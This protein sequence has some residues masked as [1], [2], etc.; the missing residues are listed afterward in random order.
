MSFSSIQDDNEIINNYSSKNKISFGVEL[1]QGK[2]YLITKNKMIKSIR[3]RNNKVEGFDNMGLDESLQLPVKEKNNDEIKQLVSLQNSFEKTLQQW[4]GKYSD[5]LSQIDNNKGL[6]QQCLDTCNKH[7]DRDLLTACIYGCTSGKYIS[8]GASYRGPAPP[9]AGFLSVLEVLGSVVAVAGILAAVALLGPEIAGIALLSE[10]AFDFATIA[11]SAAEDLSA[12]L[13]AADSVLV[14]GAVAASEAMSA[15]SLASSSMFGTIFDAEAFAE[16][17]TWAITLGE[18][19][20]ESLMAMSFIVGNETITGLALYEM[21]KKTCKLKENF[22]DLSLKDKQKMAVFLKTLPGA[23]KFEEI[24]TPTKKIKSKHVNKNLIYYHSKEGF[25]GSPEAHAISSVSGRSQ[26]IYKDKGFFD[27]A[28]MGDYGPAGYKFK[29]GNKINDFKKMVNKKLSS[30]PQLPGDSWFTGKGAQEDAKS[31]SQINNVNPNGVRAEM[32]KATDAFSKILKTMP[33]DPLILQMQKADLGPDNLTETMEKL[34]SQWRDIFTSV[35]E[36]GINKDNQGSFA[37]HQQ[38][39]KSWTNT[40]EGRSGYFGDKWIVDKNGNRQDNK[41]IGKTFNLNN[42][43]DVGTGDDKNNSRMG[44]DIMIPGKRSSDSNIGGAGYCECTDGSK[45]YMDEGHPNITCNDMCY[46]ENIK[47]KGKDNLFYHDSSVWKP[48]M[49]AIPG[50]VG[51]GAFNLSP[52]MNSQTPQPWLNCGVEGS[53]PKDCP[54]GMKQVGDV[55]E[56][57]ECGAYKDRSRLPFWEQVADDVDI[58][59]TPYPAPSVANKGRICVNPLPSGGNKE[60]VGPKQVEDNGMGAQI[61]VGY[62]KLATPSQLVNSCADSK[63]PNLYIEILALRAL[64]IILGTKT[65]IMAKIIK[66]SNNAKIKTQ[67]KQSE[68]GRRLLKNLKKYQKTY[69][70]FQKN[71]SRTELL[72]GMIRDISN[73]KDSANLSYYLWFAL[74][75]SGMLVVIRNIKN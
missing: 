49:E 54:S 13:S 64:E 70:T 10:E 2:K 15:I 23:P 7:K 63:Y 24:V 20:I 45:I 53:E 4:N 73:K 5:L 8:A 44:C 29:D 58:F 6:Y 69:N 56:M 61:P 9:P 32:N 59:G 19:E 71:E 50:T 36:A 38:Y 40:M 33:N 18:S 3:K 25:T 17:F 28:Q 27:Q 47:N 34:E 57:K 51:V 37:G 26:N 41:L 72:N 62:K 14:E 75:I 30:N 46:P 68:A 22:D 48:T 21:Y 52:P 60:Y 67:L 1:T 65:E 55:K 11:V 39:C 42:N 16:A 31:V 74:A 12:I 66:K 43:S 35:C